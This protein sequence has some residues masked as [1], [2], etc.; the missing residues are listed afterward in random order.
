MPAVGIAAAF[1]VGFG[2]ILFQNGSREQECATELL[3]LNDWTELDQI[4]YNLNFEL[5]NSMSVLAENAFSR[6]F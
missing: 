4:T 5:D 3:A 1:A 6:E 2:V